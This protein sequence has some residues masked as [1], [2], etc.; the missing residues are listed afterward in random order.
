MD[1]ENNPIFLRLAEIG[2]VAFLAWLGV[3]AVENR[4]DNAANSQKIVVL[5][6]KLT[7][8]AEL[9]NDVTKMQ[10]TLAVIEERSRLLPR[11]AK[12]SDD[13]DGEAGH[14]RP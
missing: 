8:L 12:A 10:T 9:R 2:V 7:G 4:A 13:R 3:S 11:I 1:L 5:S 14:G 6:E